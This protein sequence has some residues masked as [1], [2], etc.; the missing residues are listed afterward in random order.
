MIKAIIKAFI[1]L[2]TGYAGATEWMIIVICVLILSSLIGIITALF[3][4]VRFG[5]KIVLFPLTILFWL[6][7]PTK[8]IY[9]SS[10]AIAHFAFTPRFIFKTPKVLV[11]IYWLFGVIWLLIYFPYYIIKCFVIVP[12]RLVQYIRKKRA[13]RRIKREKAKIGIRS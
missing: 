7:K 9:K 2:F 8:R 11:P 6:F 4:G 13:K 5:A 1:A 10:H 3:K 12:I